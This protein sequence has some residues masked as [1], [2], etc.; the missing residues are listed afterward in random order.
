MLKVSLKGLW[1]HKRRLFG[2]VFAVVLGVTFLVGT[3]VLGD[4]MR[5]GFDDLFTE[6]NRGTDAVVR[7]STEVGTDQTEQRGLIDV[8]LVDTI[9]DVDGVRAAEASVTGF[10]QIVGKN[11]DP[12][13]GNGPPTIAASWTPDDDLNPWTVAD[14]NPPEAEGQVAIDKKVADDEDIVIGDRITILTPNPTEVEVVGTLT[15]GGEDSLGAVTFAAFT[16]EQAQALFMPSAQ[17]A[18]EISVA[19][20]DG[21][22]QE[23][24]VENIGPVLPD[25]IEAITGENLTE[26]NN[27][28]I[29]QDFLGFF[30]TF[31]LVFA[32]VA[33]LVATFSI[34]NT[35]SILIAQRTRE[36]ALLRA[37]GASRFQVL[38]S[39]ALEALAIGLLASILGLAAG[40]GLAVGL[41]ALFDALGFGVP[42]GAITVKTGTVIAAFAVGMVVTFLATV[43]P[44]IRA[45]RVPPLAALR[46]VAIEKTG[47]S[48]VRLTLGLLLTL[49]GVGLVIAAGVGDAGLEAAGLGAVFTIVGMVILGPIA[50]RP[51]AAV[52]GRP[53]AA[54]RKMTGQLARENAMRNPRRTA[55]TASALMVG[56]AVVTLFT[57]FAASVKAA[58]DDTVSKQFQ[59]DLVI[60][61]QNFS[62]AGLSP[63]MTEEIAAL[64]EVA[65]ATGQ[66]F[67]TMTID[68]DDVDVSNVEPAN[69]GRLLDLDVLEG[70]VEDLTDTQIG[71]SQSEADARG[72]ELGDTVTGVFPADGATAEFEIGAIYDRNTLAGDYII[73]KTT[74]NAHATQQFDIV[75]MIEL[76]E[77]VTLADGQAAVQDVADRFFAPDVQTRQEY[78]DTVADQ[79]NIFLT[80]V[81][82]LLVLAIII[83]LFGIANTLSLSVYER[84]RELGLLR[85]VGQTRSQL[86]SMVRWESVI[87]AVF[88]TIG[89]ILV[90]LFLGW[91]ILEVTARAED[92]PAPFTI[93][94]GQLLGVLLV[95]AIVGVIAGWR[96]ARRASKLDILEA[97]ATE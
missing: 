14:G 37:I 42:T 60:A 54:V 12:V 89:G 43:F 39:I 57:V 10:G 2:T 32:G 69:F 47:V 67:G 93:P 4:T 73:S 64:P 68:G 50:A 87:I 29:N 8:S 74:W 84:I 16:F 23:Q 78:V 35:F 63:Q 22:S 6:V 77:G 19:A 81:Y 66:G 34:Y 9:R 48:G 62:A 15:I 31:L 91:G 46:D 11:G 88:G 1:A 21:V 18:S 59:G 44:A 3:L 70:S 25:G 13:G 80:I 38:V 72:F 33:L 40:I 20:D 24:L 49:A 94:V 85:A 30:E 58:I 71:M 86:R 36:S 55:A 51:A 92:F 83:A 61:T 26:E 79:I 53:V 17:V 7:S 97:I 65:I 56:V 28:D 96:P 27:E 82:A 90:G 95:G 76:A 52:L 45:S 5:A 75:V 41:R